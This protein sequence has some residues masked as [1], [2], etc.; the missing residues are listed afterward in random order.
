MAKS[1]KVNPRR[2]PATM[3]DI[4]KAKADATDQAMTAV[5]YMVLYGLIDK[6]GYTQEQIMEVK[7]AFDYVIDSV[8]QGYIKWQDIERVLDEEYQIKLRFV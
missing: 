6:L 4:K 2:R 3:A 5:L 7:D 8:D 1:K